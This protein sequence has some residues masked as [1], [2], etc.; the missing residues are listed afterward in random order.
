MDEGK[1]KQANTIFGN[2]ND[3][4]EEEVCYFTK[5]AEWIS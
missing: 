4:Y 3:M 5:E 2:T 1:H